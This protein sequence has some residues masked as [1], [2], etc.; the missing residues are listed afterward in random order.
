MSTQ[1]KNIGGKIQI[2]RFI[3]Y[4]CILGIQKI[5]DYPF[6]NC[7]RDYTRSLCCFYCYQ[8]ISVDSFFGLFMFTVSCEKREGFFFTDKR[9]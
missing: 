3:R 9:R 2:F 5:R 6:K 7:S 8:D 1:R 4:Y